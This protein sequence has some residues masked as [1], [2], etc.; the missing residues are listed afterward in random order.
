M[1]TIILSPSQ[2]EIPIEDD[3]TVLSALEAAGL[4][5]PSNCRAGAC[6]ECKARVLKGEIDQGFILDMALPKKDRDQ[7]IGLMCMAKAKS[8]ILELEYQTEE[9]YTPEFFPAKEKRPYILIEKTK[10][11]P[12]IYKIKLRSLNESMRFWPGQNIILHSESLSIAPGL[13]FSM[14]NTPNQSG[15]IELYINID[16]KWIH[17]AR[18]GENFLVSGP[19][20]TFVGNPKSEKSVLCLAAGSGLAAIKS[21]ASAAMLKGGFRSPATV[22]FSAKSQDDLFELGYFSFLKAKF[23]NFDFRY[24]LTQESSKDHDKGRIPSI[25]KESFPDLSNFDV[26][27]SGNKEFVENCTQAAILLGATTQSIYTENE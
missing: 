9:S 21:L 3:Q 7:G 13:K 16:H 6:G 10:V 14:A 5:L 23:K 11:T 8:K 19:Y 25:L 24:T 27:I 22:F 12:S 1:K 18:E 26:Y 2:Q 15:E 17:E 20:G 4:S